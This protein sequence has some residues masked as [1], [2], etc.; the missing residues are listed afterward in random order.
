MTLITRLAAV[1]AAVTFALSSQVSA[2]EWRLGHVLPPSHPANIALEKAA[3]QILEKTGGRV[4]IKVF[5]SSQIGGAKEVLTGMTLGTHQM[6]FDGAGILSQ[7]SPAMGVFE[8]PFLAGDFT[9]VDHWLYMIYMNDQC[10]YKL[11]IREK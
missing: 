11:H 7:W 9:H 10:I 8:A 4:D 1:T 6:A 5:P 2:A 3:A